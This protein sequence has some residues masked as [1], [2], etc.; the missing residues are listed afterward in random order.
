MAEQKYDFF[1]EKKD[2]VLNSELLQF[3]LIRELEKKIFEV[4]EARS[5]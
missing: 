1:N 4:Q 2:F 3:N 5:F